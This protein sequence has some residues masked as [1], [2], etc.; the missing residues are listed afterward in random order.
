MATVINISDVRRRFSIAG[1]PGARA[2]EIVLEPGQKADGIPDS[3]VLPVKGAARRPLPSIV[4]Q[5]TNGH[6]IPLDSDQARDYLAGQ[7]KPPARVSRAASTKPS[8]RQPAD[9]DGGI[10]EVTGN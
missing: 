10:P 2:R 3:L 1:G 5:L 8:G 9:D 4:H 7:G 6:V